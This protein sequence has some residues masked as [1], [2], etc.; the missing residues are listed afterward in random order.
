MAAL[1]GAISES[2]KLTGAANYSTWKFRIRNIL[3][4]EDLLEFLSK[5]LTAAAVAAVPVDADDGEAVENPADAEAVATLTKR[6]NRALS[7]ICLSVSDA[8]IPHIET[9]TSPSLCWTILKNLY[10]SD[11]TAR[12]IVLRNQLNSLRLEDDGSVA[13]FIMKAQ[14]MLNQ[15]ASIGVII[16]NGELMTNILANLPESYESLS[17]HL[18]YRENL[19]TFSEFSALLLQEEV[20]RDLKDT[21]KITHEALTLG[22]RVRPT[23]F[24]QQRGRGRGPRGGRHGG[25]SPRHQ[26]IVPRQAAHTYGTSQDHD[27]QTHHGPDDLYCNWCGIVGHRLRDCP[28]FTNE[29]RKR[30]A[31]RKGKVSLNATVATDTA[32]ELDG[33]LTDKLGLPYLPDDLAADLLEANLL[34]TKPAKPLPWILDSGAS[35]SVTGNANTL[36]NLEPVVTTATITTAGGEAHPV[37]GKGTVVLGSNAPI[38]ESVLYVPGIQ[39][40]LLSVGSLAD[41]GLRI[42]FDKSH[43]FLLDPSLRTLGVGTRHPRTGLYQF[44]SV[45]SPISLNAVSHTPA[46]DLTRLWHLRLGH[47]NYKSLLFMSQHPIALGLPKL[48]PPTDPCPTCALGK[49]TRDRAPKRSPNRS[50]VP[51][52]LI[53]SDLCGPLPQPSLSGAK[54]VLTFTDDCSRYCWVYFLSK[55]SLVLSFFQAFRATIEAQLGLK[56]LCLRSDNGGE[57]SSHTFRQYCQTTGITQQFTQPHTPHQNGIAERKNR[58]LLNIARSISLMSHTPAVLWAEAVQTANFLINVTPSRANLGLTP[59]QMLTGRQPDLHSLRVFGCVCFV[60][61]KPAG[62]KLAPRAHRGVFVGYDQQTKGYRIFLP[63]RRRIILSKDVVFHKASF[64]YS[65]SPSPTSLP[66]PEIVQFSFD[67]PAPPGPISPVA[68]PTPPSPSHPVD[69]PTPDLPS[70]PSFPLSPPRS[71]SPSPPPAPRVYQRR[72]PAQPPPYPSIS[73]PYFP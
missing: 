23:F 3:Q 33:L 68:V 2:I 22:T 67:S 48:S 52:G 43:A 8:V 69:L 62:P 19:P 40:N 16:P 46:P 20:R 70:D 66:R 30:A 47:L 29:L 4:K 55:K 12:K 53:H 15:L 25:R 31:V 1:D 9:V 73:P 45:S 54:Y 35:A 5:D 41:R 71:L 27:H 7:I 72:L 34:Q 11:S 42:L 58:S 26:Y 37:T 14:T 59:Y 10:E 17:S 61:I 39:K 36:T 57:Y 44:P 65:S 51:L 56:L 32:G 50:S 49:Q 60:H 13:E 21:R 38:K 18:I 64:Y 63:E 28:E 6:R 24:S